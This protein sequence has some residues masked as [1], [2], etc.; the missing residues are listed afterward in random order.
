MSVAQVPERIGVPRTC[1]PQP[2]AW[3]ATGLSRRSHHPRVGGEDVPGVEHA[4]EAP[5]LE[6]E[7]RPVSLE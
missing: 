7:S 1:T 3:V 5:E 2:G 4:D 6:I